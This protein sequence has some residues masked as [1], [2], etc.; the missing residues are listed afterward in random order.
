MTWREVA[1]VA[2]GVLG[3]PERVTCIPEWLIW[4]VVRLVRLFNRQGELLA[5]FTTMATTDVVAPATGTRTLAAHFASGRAM[6][7]GHR[8]PL[9]RETVP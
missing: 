2:F 4:P 6:D 9:P 7:F 1:T 3:R 5:F 8:A